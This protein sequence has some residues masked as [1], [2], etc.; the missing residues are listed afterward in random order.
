MSLC[1]A[2]RVQLVLAKFVARSTEELS[3]SRRE[4]PGQLVLR[5]G[6]RLKAQQPGHAT[7]LLRVTGGVAQSPGCGDD[8]A[9]DGDRIKTGGDS[10]DGLGGE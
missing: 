8:R 3:A 7:G 1:S 6:Y 9:T 5:I 4:R 2:H 10:N